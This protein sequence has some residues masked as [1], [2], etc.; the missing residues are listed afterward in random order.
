MFLWNIWFV[1]LLQVSGPQSYQQSA[2]PVPAKLQTDLWNSLLV[3]E[4]QKVIKSNLKAC[5]WKEQWWTITKERMMNSTQ[6]S[7]TDLSP[8][9]Q[10]RPERSLSRCVA[11][12]EKGWPCGKNWLVHPGAD[13]PPSSSH[14]LPCVPWGVVPPG[15]QD[16]YYFFF[17]ITWHFIFF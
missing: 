3:W 12:E 16:Y 17:I 1:Q 5:L 15:G 13:N 7:S 6:S 14:V 4:N 9:S 11:A 10:S 8:A 2:S